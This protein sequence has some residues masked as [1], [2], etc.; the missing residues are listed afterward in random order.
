MNWLKLKLNVSRIAY[1]RHHWRIMMRYMTLKRAINL[2][3]NQIEYLFRREKLWSYPP[4]IKV[5]QSL[6]CQLRCPGC[7]QSREE[8]RQTLPSK[9]FLALEEF[10][11]II[12]P[13]AETTFGISLSMYGEPLLNKDIASIIEYAHSLKIG[14]WFPTNFSLKLTDEQLE[15]L[16]KSGLDKLVVSLD[17]A[18]EESYGK[19]RVNG[20]FELVKSN[21]Q[22]LANIKKELGSVTPHLE[23]KY[24]MFDHNLHE[25]DI[26][27]KEYRDWG[28]DSFFLVPDRRWDEVQAFKESSYAKK[29]ACFWV[30]NTINVQVDG[31][32]MACCANMPAW[33]IGNAITVD[34]RILWNNERFRELRRGFS[35]RNYG[36]EMDPVCVKC[37]G[38]DP[39]S[40]R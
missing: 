26:V 1:L 32:L 3:L 28:F 2:V 40:D 4:Y 5:D 31:N 18:T 22:R 39:K 15:R 9:S 17:G 7:P 27:K 10:K 24:V 36:K 20:Q 23:W 6:R 33:H 25:V 16:V 38:G 34:V 8:F 35:R 11:K 12:D 13:I 21:V 37:F 19:Y 29:E 14:V 30:F